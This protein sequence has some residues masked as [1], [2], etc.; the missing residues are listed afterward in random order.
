[1]APRN[2][3]KS[4]NNKK[5]SSMNNLKKKSIS[6]NQSTENVVLNSVQSNSTENINNIIKD[7]KSGDQNSLENISNNIDLMLNNSNNSIDK[8]PSNY[9]ITTTYKTE[10]VECTVDTETGDIIE[11]ITEIYVTDS[12]N[13]NKNNQ[14]IYS[15]SANEEELSLEDVLNQLNYGTELC[16]ELLGWRWL[17]NN[18]FIKIAIYTMQL[19]KRK[20][21]EYKLYNLIN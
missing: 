10:L 20:K 7:S 21:N 9:E 3:K 8:K 11:V 13:L 12:I 14:S 17:L 15:T 1:M 16:K 2:S 18:I 6:P 5:N 4:K 19:H